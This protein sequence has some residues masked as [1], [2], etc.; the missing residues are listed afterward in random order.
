MKTLKYSVIM[1][2][3][4]L[5]KVIVESIPNKLF[6]R[7]DSEPLTYKGIQQEHLMTALKNPTAHTPRFS[8]LPNLY[9]AMLYKEQNLY[10]KNYLKW[11]LTM[12][13][14]DGQIYVRSRRDQPNEPMV[15]AYFEK[16]VG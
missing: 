3:K 16:D 13:Y 7:V 12:E 9:Q 11:T 14:P 6:D 15:R 5:V 1:R 10:N 4:D 2:E 8:T